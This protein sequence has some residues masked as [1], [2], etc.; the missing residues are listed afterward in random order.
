MCQLDNLG[1]KK[2]IRSFLATVEYQI[3]QIE[4][5]SNVRC[6]I[7]PIVWSYQSVIHVSFR[8]EG[9]HPKFIVWHAG[10][11]PNVKHES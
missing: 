1:E 4:Y 8:F 7:P 11:E 10:R 2:S 9:F 6:D 5:N 3:V